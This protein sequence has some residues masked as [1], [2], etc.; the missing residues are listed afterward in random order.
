MFGVPQVRNNVPCETSKEEAW[1]KPDHGTM[2]TGRTDIA[3]TPRLD[4]EHKSYEEE[5]KRESSRK[6]P[7]WVTRWQSEQSGLGWFG[8]L[9]HPEDTMCARWRFC[10]YRKSGRRSRKRKIEKPRGRTMMSVKRQTAWD[11]RI[12]YGT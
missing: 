3:T 4:P 1:R 12:C 7:L 6:R 8:G 5:Q 2:D 11:M 10:W 9:R